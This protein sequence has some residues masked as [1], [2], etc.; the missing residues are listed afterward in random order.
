MWKEAG[1]VS[2]CFPFGGK[3][4]DE[5]VGDVF[6]ELAEVVNVKVSLVNSGVSNSSCWVDE[7]MV[8]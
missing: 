1:K 6:G 4:F 2:H 3:A 7:G 8:S 5:G